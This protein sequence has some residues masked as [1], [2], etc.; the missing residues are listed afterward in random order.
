MKITMKLRKEGEG[1][2]AR[3]WHMLPLLLHVSLL[4]LLLVLLLLLHLLHLL[5]PRFFCCFCISLFCFLLVWL[6]AF[7]LAALFAHS[8]LCFCC[9][10]RA[11]HFSHQSTIS[12]T[13]N[14]E[15]PNATC[16]T[17]TTSQQTNQQQQRAALS[18]ILALIINHL[19]LAHANI[20]LYSLQEKTTQGVTLTNTLSTHNSR[21]AR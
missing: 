19:W 5:L 2:R 12:T 3:Y 1:V 7:L 8:V 20:S 6:V 18:F 17:Q 16:K 4:L 14:H 9:S 15:W 13:P 11:G 21:S 10:S